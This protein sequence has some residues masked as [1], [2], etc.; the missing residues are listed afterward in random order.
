MLVPGHADALTELQLPS[1][2]CPV[3]ADFGRVERLAA[4]DLQPGAVATLHL[5][6]PKAPD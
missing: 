3:L 4:A 6:R 5:H 1:G 2:H